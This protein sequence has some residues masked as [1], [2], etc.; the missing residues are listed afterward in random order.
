MKAIQVHQFGGPE[1][2]QLQEIPTPK[3][4]A[5]QVLVRVH[6]A[7]VNPYDTYMR[8]GTY[9]IKPPLPYTPGSD[10]AGVIEAVGEGVTKFKSGARVYTARTVSGA[11]AECA[12]ALESQ[13]HAL[14]EKISFPQGAGVWVPYG[15]A[16]TALIHHAHACPGETVLIHGASGGVGTAAAQFARAIGLIVF[17]TAGTQKGMDLAKKEG[18]H[19]TFDHSKT[20]YSD[21][22]M[23]ATGGR[24]ADVILEMLANVNLSTDLKLLAMNGRVI[25]IGNRGEITIN[26]R[27]LMA[28]RGTAKGFTL[29][30]VPEPEL[31]EIH[32]AIGA[33]LE[34][35]TLRPIVG[36][37]LPL[38]DAAKAHVD[39]LAPGAHGKI[40]LVP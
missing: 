38:K 19:Q 30:G 10:A 34:S 37:E 40:V 26:P 27:D 24:G 35:G 36:K 15:T 9:A 3:P 5:G 6:A 25:I 14:P 21:E 28:R 31:V 32:A 18:A 39:V 13:V 12:L 8:N 23:Q 33:G 17:G 22:I 2:L 20:G 1:V 4:A 29:W 11:Y 16:I 7:G